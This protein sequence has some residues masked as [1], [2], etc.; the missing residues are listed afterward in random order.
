MWRR[1]KRARSREWGQGGPVVALLP[2]ADVLLSLHADGVLCV[3]STV[4]AAADGSSGGDGGGGDG[5]ALGLVFRHSFDVGAVGRPTALLHPSTYVNKVAIGTSEGSVVVLNFRTGKLVYEAR[6]LLRGTAVTALAQSPAVDVLA[7]GGADGAVVLHNLRQDARV[8]EFAHD[9]RVARSAAVTALA[10]SSGNAL[11]AP[12]LASATEGGAL[13]LWNLERREVASSKP[14]AH[15]G[16]VTLLAFLPGQPTLLSVGAGDNAVRMWTVDKLDSSLRVLRARAGH[17]APPRLLRY[18]AGAAVASIASGANAQVCEIAS[19]SEDRTLRLFHT[20]L[21]RQNVELS[22]GHLLSR[23]NDLGV[24]PASLRLPPVVA[25]ATSDRRF[26]QWADVVTAHAGSSR[27]YAWSWERRALEERS[28]VMPDASEPALCVAISACGHFAFAGGAR[29]TLAAFNLQS[30]ARRGVFPPSKLAKSSMVA[31]GKKRGALHPSGDD[32]LGPVDRDTGRGHLTGAIAVDSIDHLLV[33]SAGLTPAARVRDRYRAPADGVARPRA[34]ASDVFGGS[35]AFAAAGDAAAAADGTRVEAHA[36]ARHVAAVTGVASD[37]LNSVVVSVDGDGLVI[38][39][40]F[41]SHAPVAALRLPSGARAL[42]L[43]RESGLAAVACDDFAV[44]LLDVVSRRLVR[45]FVGHTN[46]VNDVTFSSDGRWLVSASLDSSVRVWDLATARCID[47]MVFSSAPV[48]VAFSPTGEY[49][50]TAHAA[51]LGLCLWANRAHFG[52]VVVEAAALAPT[53]MDFPTVGD[54]DADTAAEGGGAAV[55]P[56]AAAAPVVPASSSAAL[57]LP[58]PSA[59]VEP[60]TGFH[61]TLSG[62]PPSAWVNLSQLQAIAERNAPL[63]P[64]KKPDAAP[65]F[66]PTTGGLNPVF[67]LPTAPSAD[68]APDAKRPRSGRLLV[69][70]GGLGARTALAVL[71]RSAIDAEGR[72]GGDAAA[73]TAAAAAHKAVSDHLASLAPASVDVE[74]RSLCLA[75]GSADGE[76]LLGALLRYFCAELKSGRRFDLAQAHIGLALEA[77]QEILP[78]LRGDVERLREAQAPAAA[79]L[80]DCLDK[81]LALVSSLLGQ[82]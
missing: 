40:D 74:I 12:L 30:G 2:L 31:R 41:S 42:T 62:L 37:A 66:L 69:S 39:W 78:A 15:D 25:L 43:S 5:D 47:W 20:A 64:A 54:A 33:A 57:T 38:W 21:D 82:E 23:A 44:R 3:W 29:G 27:V 16:R 52:V 50:V 77:H 28:L 19:A 6:V 63:E 72:G 67:A 17:T 13:V 73:D 1:G 14:A 53:R 70:H 60:A 76:R 68:D 10:F 48:S 55:A 61:I 18:Y 75:P 51:Q 32:F 71:L 11:S 8:A 56:A 26:G 35:A 80:V 65:F 36:G 9:R 4:G 7:V 22:Q 34:G 58:A 24:A 45:S 81:G 59:D 79:L 49:L 46:R